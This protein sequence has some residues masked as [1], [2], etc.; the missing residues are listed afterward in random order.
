MSFLSTWNLIVAFILTWSLYLSQK[1]DTE[2]SP[3]VK[4]F[5]QIVA[6]FMLACILVSAYFL[7]HT[8][9]GIYHIWY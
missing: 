1:D 7:R 3:T 6:G 9:P 4:R 2:S 8:G 5:V